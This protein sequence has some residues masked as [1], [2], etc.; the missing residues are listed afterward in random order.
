MRSFARHLLT[1]LQNRHVWDIP[2][3]MVEPTS[4]IAFSAKLVFTCAATFTRLS[5]H[6]FYYRLVGDTGKKW[7]KW[8]VHANVAY[9][10]GIFIS[11]IFITIF[12]CVPVR[13]YWTIGGTPGAICLDEGVV[14]FVA[15]IINCLADFLTT[16][17]PIPLIF[18]VSVG[19]RWWC[20]QI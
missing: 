20:D 14:T 11:Y 17:T 18:G 6:C 7:F 2:F 10:L 3:T 13:A 12:L 15:G 16:I 5:L 19:P 8:L 9:T 4:K 1:D